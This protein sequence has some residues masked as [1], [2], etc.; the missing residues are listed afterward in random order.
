MF[1]KTDFNLLKRF[2]IFA[3][4]FLSIQVSKAQNFVETPIALERLD[5]KLL[6]VRQAEDVGNATSTD[7]MLTLNYVDYMKNCLENG[8]AIEPALEIG[9]NKTI[10][11]YSDSIY[12]DQIALL[13][14]ELQELLTENDEENNG[15]N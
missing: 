5:T 4:L 2:G 14:K 13:K 3:L 10:E 15:Q 12:M 9:H 7:L 1:S 6:E 8:Q 11:L